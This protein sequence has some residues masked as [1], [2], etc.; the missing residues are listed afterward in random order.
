MM[1]NPTPLHAGVILY[2]G[3]IHFA[4]GYAYIELSSLPAWALLISDPQLTGVIN[5]AVLSQTAVALAANHQ[6][7]DLVSLRGIMLVQVFNGQTL[8]VL[9]IG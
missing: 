8:H 3:K 2:N 1:T 9:H 5:L 6:E 4:N 7:G